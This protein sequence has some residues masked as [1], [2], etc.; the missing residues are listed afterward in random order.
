MFFVEI[1]E[2][3]FYGNSFLV[4]GTLFEFNLDQKLKLYYMFDQRIKTKVKIFVNEYKHD[5]SV[6]IYN[7]LYD[8]TMTTL[9]YLR[10]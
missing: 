7:V 5:K 4:V 9:L 1:F 10:Y 2:F 3:Y 8:S 6:P